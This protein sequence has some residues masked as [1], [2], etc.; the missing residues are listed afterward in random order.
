MTSSEQAAMR[1]KDISVGDSV[2]FHP[3]SRQGNKSIW[4]VLSV[5]NGYV[6]IKRTHGISGDSYRFAKKR[7]DGEWYAYVPFRYVKKVNIRKNYIDSDGKRRIV[8][9]AP[10][11]VVQVTY[12]DEAFTIIDY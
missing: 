2:F 12:V 3:N 9:I 1:G 11:Q 4:E 8:A 10:K 6:E 5:H 7:S